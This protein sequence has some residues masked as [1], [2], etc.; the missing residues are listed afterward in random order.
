MRPRRRRV[1]PARAARGLSSRVSHERRLRSPRERDQRQHH[2]HQRHERQ[3][4]EHPVSQSARARR[5]DGGVAGSVRGLAPNR[6][7]R[8]RSFPRAKR[9]RA[10]GRPWCAGGAD[11]A[12]RDHSPAECSAGEPSARGGRNATGGVEEHAAC[13]LPRP[14]RRTPAQLKTNGDRRWRR[15]RSRRRAARR[16]R[17]STPPNV[18]HRMEHAGERCAEHC[19]DAHCRADHCCADHCCNSACRAAYHGASGT[20]HA[21]ERQCA[22]AATRTRRS[23]RRGRTARPQR[24]V[25]PNGQTCAQCRRHSRTRIRVPRPS[26][27]RT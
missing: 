13:R 2:Q 18:A 11:A 23:Q 12:E 20:Q 1:V 21:A 24:R 25:P 7:R 15:F 26:R 3:R 14:S 8:R 16:A 27:S 5:D 17:A 22:L 4:H 10:R 19:T 9:A 6:P